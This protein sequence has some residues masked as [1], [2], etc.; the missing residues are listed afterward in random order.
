VFLRKADV[1]AD[2]GSRRAPAAGS[3]QGMSSS[4]GFWSLDPAGGTLTC[5]PAAADI[6]GIEVSNGRTL[7]D[8]LLRLQPAD[9]RRL[10]RAGL[11]SA[12]KQSSFDIVVLMRLH[13][14]F[15]LLRVIGGAGYDPGQRDP[16]VHGV[17]EQIALGPA[18]A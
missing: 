11:A 2:C 1:A 14:A 10:L 3:I 6:L 5:C 4:L 16:H 7:A 12:R 9:R 17:V 13:G 18:G 8:V 15:R